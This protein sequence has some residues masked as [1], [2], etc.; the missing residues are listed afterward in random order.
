MEG[1]RFSSSALK[2]GIEIAR[3]TDSLLVGI[4][5]RDLKYAGYMYPIMFDQPYAETSA[6]S[7]FLKEERETINMTIKAFNDQCAK[8]HIAHHVHLDEAAPIEGLLNESAYADLIVMDSQ[9]NISSL[10][11]DSPSS[12]LSDIL[13]DAHCPVLIV[14][15]SFHEIKNIILSYDGSHSSAYAIRMFNYIFPEWTDYKTTLLTVADDRNSHLKE[16]TNIRE[17]IG[18][19]YT[20][21][22]Y[23][24]MKGDVS[25]EIKKFM[26]YNSTESIMVMG[27]YSRNALS[28]LWRQSLANMIISESKVPVFISHQ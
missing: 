6:Y 20:N 21:V 4:F 19:H 27:A 1:N 3:K 13:V 16:N 15:T 18:R 23:Q 24:I 9:M 28:R 14:P 5:M 10:L 25:K 26:K 8:E 2:Y 12:T 22:T 7:E 11:P 17:L